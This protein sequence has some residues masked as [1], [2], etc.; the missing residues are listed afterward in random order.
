MVAVFRLKPVVQ[1][2]LLLFNLHPS[3]YLY[4]YN[5]SDLIHF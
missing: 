4:R 1:N 2:L 5:L 3:V